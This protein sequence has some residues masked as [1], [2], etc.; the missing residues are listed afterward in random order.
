MDLSPCDLYPEEKRLLQW[1]RDI[2]GSHS[3]LKELSLP[4]VTHLV[5]H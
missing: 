3:C 5:F 4:T 2:L 1:D